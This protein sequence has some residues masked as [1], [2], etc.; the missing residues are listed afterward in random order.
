MCP[1]G[2]ELSSLLGIIKKV[3]A[4]LQIGIPI[5]LLLFGTLDLGKAVMAGDEKEI[6]AATS[7]LLKRA[8]AAIAVFLL[9]MIVTLVTGW[10]GGKEWS[11]CWKNANKNVIIDNTGI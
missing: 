9:F 1:S 4:I 11:T 2:G 3:L 6:K 5:V 10:V 7:I 8:V